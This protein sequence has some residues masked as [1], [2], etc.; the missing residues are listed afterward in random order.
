VLPCSRVPQGAEGIDEDTGSGA[1]LAPVKGEAP[2]QAPSA[3]PAGPP[4]LILEIERGLL[5]DDLALFHGSRRA[6]M[7]VLPMMVFHRV[8][9]HTRCADSPSKPLPGQ[10]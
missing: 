7:S 10:P 2:G 5:P 9:G 8:E 1:P 6:L 4:T 3:R